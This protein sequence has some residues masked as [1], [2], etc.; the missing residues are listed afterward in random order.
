MRWS[1]ALL[2]ICAPLSNGSGGV[3]QQGTLA[4]SGGVAQQGTLA[5]A[6]PAAANVALW[7]NAA[8]AVTAAMALMQSAAVEIGAT[9]MA[10]SLSNMQGV[11]KDLTKRVKNLETPNSEEALAAMQEK[12]RDWTQLAIQQ[13]MAG[14]S[15]KEVEQFESDP[16][17]SA[18]AKKLHQKLAELDVVF[19]EKQGRS[20]PTP[21]PNLK[22][23]ATAE[24]PAE[25]AKSAPAENGASE[26]SAQK[27]EDSVAIAPA[28]DQTRSPHYA[29]VASASTGFAVGLLVVGALAWA[30]ERVGG[31]SKG[32]V[33]F[34][35]RGCATPIHSSRK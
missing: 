15:A 3:A 17:N 10:S 14:L 5:F 23:K 30:R 9:T 13:V 8:A 6:I 24:A 26:V 25:E 18:L 2:C 19:Q 34:R 20:V 29:Q 32:R 22:T 7:V 27:R 4:F 16:K 31:G 1:L 28:D 33:A 12:V 21:K 11:L 35:G